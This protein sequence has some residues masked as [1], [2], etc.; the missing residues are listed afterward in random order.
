MLVG[1]VL[2]TVVAP[3]QHA[4]YVG[5]KL[6]LVPKGL[7]ARNPIWSTKPVTASLTISS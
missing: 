4:F 2:G 5:Q 7:R 3:I 6:L 1:T